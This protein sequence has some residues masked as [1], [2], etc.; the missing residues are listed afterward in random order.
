MLLMYRNYKDCG[1]VLKCTLCSLPVK[2]Q[3]R[4]DPGL[5]PTSREIR[6]VDVVGT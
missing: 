3:Q 1:N 5:C 4:E 6:E 2:W